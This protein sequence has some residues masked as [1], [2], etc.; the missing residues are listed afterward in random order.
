MT[1]VFVRRFSHVVASLHN[2]RPFDS[3]VHPS[4]ICKASVAGLGTFYELLSACPLTMPFLGAARLSKVLVFLLDLPDPVNIGYAIFSII[5]S[6]H[7][8]VYCWGL[9]KLSLMDLY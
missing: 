4:A 1:A 7:Q 5:S 2:H 6:R 8:C 3:P 9:A